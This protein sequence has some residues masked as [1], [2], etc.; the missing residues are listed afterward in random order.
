MKR[1]NYKAILKEMKGTV[2]ERPNRTTAG[3]LSGHAAGE[4]FEKSVYQHLKRNYPDAI[5]TTASV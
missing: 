1:V 2:V 4:P 3:T 5:F